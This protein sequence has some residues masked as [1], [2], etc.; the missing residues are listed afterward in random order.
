MYLCLCVCV[1]ADKSVF[2]VRTRA[3]IFRN[4]S[5]AT[6]TAM[7]LSSP[8]PPPPYSSQ[9]CRENEPLAPTSEYDNTSVPTRSVLDALKE[10]SR[11]RIHCEVVDDEQVK[12]S[13]GDAEEP[14]TGDVAAAAAKSISKRQRDDNTSPNAANTST[15]SSITKRQC[16]K[17]NE[18]TS[19]LS[20]SL[21]LMRPKRKVGKL[22]T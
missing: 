12:K 8:P 19:S 21:T 10:I 16:S 2:N 20:S 17:N 9:A 7:G 11:K 5:I 14:S 6:G 13:K 4:G 15:S 1:C 18:I 3:E 22:C